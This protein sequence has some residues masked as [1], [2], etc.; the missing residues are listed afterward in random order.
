MQIDHQIVSAAMDDA[1]DGSTKPSLGQLSA[2]QRDVWARYHLISDVL[3]DP[4]VAV[5]PAEFS[6]EVRDE[7]EREP[8]LL[9]RAEKLPRS[10]ARPLVGF[11]VAASVAALA[12]IGV[13]KMQLD[14]RTATTPVAISA[15]IVAPAQV[16]LPAQ[17]VP[18]EAAPIDIA[19]VKFN[20]EPVPALHSQG[21]LNGY[22]VK[23]N[24]QRSSVGVPGVNPYVRIVGFD[25]E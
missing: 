16:D 11:A 4:A 6:S 15:S 19:L 23:F 20:D 5:A 14:P 25:S 12:V 24:E 21:R 8:F 1:L 17:P 3:R 2:S 18:V 7:V 9:V 13:Q 10:F 22:L